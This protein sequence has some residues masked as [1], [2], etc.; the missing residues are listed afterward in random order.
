MSENI[1]AY[2]HILFETRS[3]VAHI[4]LNRPGRMNAMSYGPG[5]NSE[6]IAQALGLADADPEV[7]CV[8]VTAAGRAFCAGGNLSENAIPECALDAHLFLERVTHSRVAIR[9]MHKP[10]IAAVNGLCLGGGL[11]FA[12]QC[13]FVLAADDARFGLVEGRFG[14]GG[15]AAVVGRIG[16]MWAKF[17]IWT[18]EMIDARRARKIGLVLEVIPAAELHERAWDLAK[19]IARMPRE[20]VLL[21]KACVDAM[22]HCL[23]GPSEIAGRAGEVITLSMIQHAR[24]SDGRLFA[25]ILRE[26]GMAGLKRARDAQFTTRWLKESDY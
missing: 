4:T 8:L 21:N 11:G 19:R 12:S 26:E 23:R 17:L 24:A 22:E 14:A 20:A 16:P 25:E 6:E 10:V 1:P 13:D 15:V 18:G 5:S 2:Q 7:G 3:G 9:G